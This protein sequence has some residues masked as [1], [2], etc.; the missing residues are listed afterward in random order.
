LL[1]DLEETLADRAKRSRRGKRPAST[2]G[3]PLADASR[4]CRL[5]TR[6]RGALAIDRQTGAFAEEVPE[7]DHEGFRALAGFAAD[8]STLQVNP[9]VSNI[10]FG[11]ICDV[12]FDCLARDGKRAEVLQGGALALKHLNTQKSRDGRPVALP[13]HV[14]IRFRQRWDLPPA[15]RGKRS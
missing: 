11:R 5:L 12:L 4:W 3:H 2:L 7:F 8:Y 6:T 14:E 13:P 1:G 10:T 9:W 15:R